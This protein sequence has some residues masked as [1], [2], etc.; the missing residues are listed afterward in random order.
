[1]RTL[2]TR[3]NGQ[4]SKYMQM[5]ESGQHDTPEA[6]KLRAKLDVSMGKDHQELRRCDV[7]IAQI[8]VLKAFNAKRRRE[9]VG[10]RA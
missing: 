6:L 5:I 7:R 4:L 1:M 3:P 8:P 9:A 10:G 2:A